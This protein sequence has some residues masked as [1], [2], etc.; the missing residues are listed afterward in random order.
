MLMGVLGVNG[1]DYKLFTTN[2]VIYTTIA[3]IAAES[4]WV[5]GKSYTER[6][7]QDVTNLNPETD[8][9]Y[10]SST[11][12]DGIYVKSVDTRSAWFYITG[13]ERVVIYYQSSSTSNRTLTAD[14]IPSDGSVTLSNSVA[15][16]KV[17]GASF[18]VTGLD[19]SKKYILK[20]YASGDMMI[21]AIKFIVPAA[22]GTNS[23]T[24]SVYP[25]N[26]GTVTVD[27][28]KTLYSATDVVTLTPTPKEGYEFVNWTG[29][30]AADV[31]N[32][33]GV[34]TI[35]MDGNKEVV[36]NFTEITTPSL[37]ATESS[38]SGFEYEE[39]KGPSASQTFSLSGVALTAGTI[40]ITAPTG[41][42]VSTDDENFGSTATISAT[43]GSL[44]ATL[45]YVKLVDEAVGTY[46]GDIT[47]SGTNVGVTTP[48]T[49]ACEGEVTA[50]D[51]FIAIKASDLV[52]KSWTSAD[53]VL[54][55]YS[56]NTTV[57]STD[58]Y[59]MKIDVNN[60]TVKISKDGIRISGSDTRVS[61]KLD[62]AFFVYATVVGAGDSRKFR[63]Y[64]DNVQ[65]VEHV[66]GT[67][68]TTF[69]YYYDG[70]A[71]EQLIS[72]GINSSAFIKELKVIPAV[73][74]TVECDGQAVKNG[75]V[76]HYYLDEDVDKDT[77][78]VVSET[79]SMYPLNATITLTAT[80]STD[81]YLKNWTGHAASESSS[82]TTSQLLMD[83]P[84]TVGAE[85]DITTGIDNTTSSKAVVSVKYYTVTGV[86]VAEDAKGLVIVKTTYEDGSIE[87]AKRILE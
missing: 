50:A 74:L 27:P 79:V 48:I 51:T 29:T 75:E 84:K 19:A 9:A 31:V 67:E 21:Y 14:L 58:N 44:A 37:S 33:D 45:V 52:S 10:T 41:F 16:A 18:S 87:T 30:D 47:I 46:N 8:L 12:L 17:A 15:S 85:F 59:T 39:G 69:V 76:C 23:L 83:G 72:V 5:E 65:K 82:N 36:A 57:Y 80:P 3:N 62:G 34:Y 53:F 26:A 86:E 49:V 61:V 28:E 2:E 40:T 24:T 38:L 25:E 54:A 78:V 77:K 71:T 68:E 35:T 7:S 13:V 20:P 32:T 6:K 55:D 22:T 70:T 73:S 56:G 1:Q 42:E 66:F 64:E 4:D 63:F 60:K 11:K 43:N 81:Y